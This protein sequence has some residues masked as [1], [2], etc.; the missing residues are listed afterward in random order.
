MH[1]TTAGKIIQEDENSFWEF[2][3]NNNP[4]GIIG[5]YKQQG[6][7]GLPTTGNVENV[8]PI[9][10]NLLNQKNYKELGYLLVNTPYLPNVNNVTTNA[11]LWQSMG[12]NQGDY[13]T[14]FK[15]YYPNQYALTTLIV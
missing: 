5:L 11:A 4:A 9:L 3:A 8:Y 1:V 13:L 2:F 6:N 15:T 10:R 12:V 14:L 7:K